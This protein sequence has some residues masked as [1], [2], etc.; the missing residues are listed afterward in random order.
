[1]STSPVEYGYVDGV[2]PLS[3]YR[4]GGYHPVHIDDRLDKRYRI[5]HKLG[6]G[7]FST[8]WLAIDEKTSK[9]VAVKVGTADADRTEIDVLSQLTQGAGSCSYPK[10]EISLVPVVLDQFDLDGPNGT[11]PCLVTLPAR[12]SLRDAREASSLSLIHI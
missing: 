2:E 12:C 4:S 7:T 3:D 6:H 10:D 9:Y 8:A 1:M 5:L 11:H